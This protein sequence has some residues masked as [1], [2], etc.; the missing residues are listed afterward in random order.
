MNSKFVVSICKI[1]CRECADG[2]KVKKGVFNY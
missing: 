2:E 1:Y